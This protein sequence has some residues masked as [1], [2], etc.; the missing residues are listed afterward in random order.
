MGYIIDTDV[1][2][3][4]M[5]NKRDAFNE[6]NK[7]DAELFLTFMSVSELF[8]GAY[9][10]DRKEH[11]VSVTKAFI[12]NFQ[13]LSPS[14]SS[15]ELFGF[16]KSKLRNEGKLIPDADLLIGSLAITYNQVLFTRNVTHFERLADFGLRLKNR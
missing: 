12:K 13:V 4:L 11:Q 8:Y 10:S 15:S 1:C 14:L 6:I 5:R 16:I 7:L 3:D 9:Y 2:I